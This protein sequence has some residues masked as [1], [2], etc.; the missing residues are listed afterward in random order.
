M[1]HSA[2]GQLSLGGHGDSNRKSILGTITGG[3]NRKRSGLLG[4]FTN[5][6][7]IAHRKRFGANSV[8][9]YFFD[10]HFFVLVFA[11]VTL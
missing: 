7:V 1:M 5:N 9:M 4:L 8:D 6:K 11:E 3:R 2:L 10:S